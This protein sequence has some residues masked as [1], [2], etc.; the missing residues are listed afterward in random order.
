VLEIRDALLED[1]DVR[2]DDCT[3]DL[4][5]LLQRLRAWKLIELRNGKSSGPS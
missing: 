5:D 4:I 2:P 3:R 1:Y